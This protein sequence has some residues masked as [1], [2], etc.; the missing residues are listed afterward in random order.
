MR[1][2][3]RPAVRRSASAGRDLTR[4]KPLGIGLGYRVQLRDYI[5]SRRDRFDFLEVVPDILWTDLGRSARPRYRDIEEDV[6]FIGDVART[7]PVIPG[8]VGKRAVRRSLPGGTSPCQPLH[9]SV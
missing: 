7:M 2:G 6:A 5:R 3:P 1:S 4:L 9:T 8:M